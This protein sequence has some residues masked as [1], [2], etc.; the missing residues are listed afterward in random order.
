MH[1]SKEFPGGI[2]NGAQWYPLWGGMQDWH[3]LQ[4]QTLDI[5]IEVNDEKWPKEGELGKIWRE[6]VGGIFACALMATRGAVKGFVR[7]AASNE[8][9]PTAVLKIEGVDIAFAPNALGF[10]ARP[11]SGNSEKDAGKNFA[12]TVT[13]SADGYTSV[14]ETVSVHQVEGGE[15]VFALRK[16]SGGG[17]GNFGSSRDDDGLEDDLFGSPTP[18]RR[19]PATVRGLAA[20]VGGPHRHPE[21]TWGAAAFVV[22]AVAATVRRRRARFGRGRG[23]VRVEGV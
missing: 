11:V 3:Y 20:T 6:H 18:T 2:T 8:A 13:A 7:D 14:T 10:F 17:G 1:H 5:T 23:V 15:V 12:V 19:D 4:T 16:G 22:L 9:L 21:T